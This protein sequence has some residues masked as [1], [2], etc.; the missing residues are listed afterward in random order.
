MKSHVILTTALERSHQYSNFTNE[1]EASSSE[2]REL[3]PYPLTLSQHTHAWILKVWP[4]EE[5]HGHQLRNL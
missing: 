1:R 2:V 4:K 3:S 5:K